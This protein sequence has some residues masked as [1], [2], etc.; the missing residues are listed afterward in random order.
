M[1]TP[2]ARPAR[3]VLATGLGSGP[4]RASIPPL[5]QE[6]PMN[7]FIFASGVDNPKHGPHDAN[8]A[9]RP[10]AQAFKKVHDIPQDIYY[11][12]WRDKDA[13]LRRRILDKLTT[14]PCDDPDGLDVV[15]YFGHGISRGLPS[16]GF[17]S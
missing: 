16:A 7:G 6:P 3:M 15:A 13:D 17:Y 4:D 9:F 11:F 12:D 14:V 8:G 10:G 2:C 5:L 1:V